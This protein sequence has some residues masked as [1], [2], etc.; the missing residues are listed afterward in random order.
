[1]P[2]PTSAEPVLVADRYEVNPKQPLPGAGGGPPAFA[3]RDRTGAY[4]PVMAVQVQ[5]RFPARGRLRGIGG[6]RA[7]AAGLGMR[8]R[9]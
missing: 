3:A 6:R 1:M 5:R 9:G 7:G 2:A 8:A 4:A